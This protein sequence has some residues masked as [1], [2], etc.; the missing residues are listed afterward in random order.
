[1]SSRDAAVRAGGP[2]RAPKA[3]WGDHLPL[4]GPPPGCPGKEPSRLREGRGG[5]QKGR[6]KKG[7]GEGPG[8]SQEFQGGGGGRR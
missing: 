1:M 8:D 2:A 6:K 3:R 5:G 4:H 7:P